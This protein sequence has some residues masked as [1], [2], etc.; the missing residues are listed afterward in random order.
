[1]NEF[2]DKKKALQIIL[3]IAYHKGIS[4]AQLIEGIYDYSHFN[5]MCNGKENIKIDILGKRQIK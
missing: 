2:F 5:R 3:D 4:Q 1:M